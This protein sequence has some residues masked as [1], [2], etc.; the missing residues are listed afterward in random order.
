MI[1]A[2]CSKYDTF[3]TSSGFVMTTD[4][5]QSESRLQP[6]QPRSVPASSSVFAFGFAPTIAGQ[7]GG[8]DHVETPRKAVWE[9]VRVLMSALSNRTPR[10]KRLLRSRKS[11]S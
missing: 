8:R 2:S 4:R 9:I 1:A 5:T 6:P 3:A 11:F 7:R 10:K